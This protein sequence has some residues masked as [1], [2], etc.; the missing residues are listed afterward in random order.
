MVFPI[1]YFCERGLFQ[2]SISSR[3]KFMKLKKKSFVFILGSKNHAGSVKE[4]LEILS[5]GKRNL[6]ISFTEGS[7]KRN[8]FT[9]QGFGTE[10]PPK[11]TKNGPTE[12]KH[13]T[14]QT[15]KK[16]KNTQISPKQIKK[17]QLPTDVDK[18]TSIQLFSDHFESQTFGADSSG[19][20]TAALMKRSA[21]AASIGT[22]SDASG[23]DD[24]GLRSR[25][26]KKRA[27]DRACRA[28]VPARP[29]HSLKDRRQG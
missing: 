29:V 4:F 25:P 15:N 18:M 2:T 9:G 5:R 21:V 8:P 6:Q 10:N 27:A 12:H 16:R 3:N 7:R 1:L 14:K 11:S 22:G 23:S 26:V 17:K 28:L 20:G 24:D 19:L 13:M